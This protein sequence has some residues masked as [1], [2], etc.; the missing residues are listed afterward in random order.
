MGFISTQ[1][2]PKNFACPR[3]KQYGATVTKI[4]KF[5]GLR[6]CNNCDALEG[7]KDHVGIDENS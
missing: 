3:C 4:S 6:I 2:K 7:L 1:T 5:D